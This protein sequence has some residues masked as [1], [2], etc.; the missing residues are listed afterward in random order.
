LVEEYRERL[1]RV[2]LGFLGNGVEAEEVA[3]ETFVQ[4]FR[5]LGQFRGESSFYTW[6][7]RICVNL[8][9]RR[10]EQLSQAQ[11]R[12]SSEVE[13]EPVDTQ[14][15]EDELVQREQAAQLR[16][17]LRAL[18]R[19]YRTALVLR[20]VNSLSYEEIAEVLGL[21]MGTVKSRVHR[22]RMLLKDRLSGY[23]QGVR[24]AP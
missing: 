6:I 5:H 15:P 17:A 16:R 2:A 10:R 18:P 3:Q 19:E 24:N 21:P 4:V 8:C 22:G 12:E 23:F 14:T 11:V 9:L 13:V 20:E 7:C 1:F